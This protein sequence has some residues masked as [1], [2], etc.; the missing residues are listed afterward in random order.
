MAWPVGAFVS[1]DTQL[2]V[3]ASLAAGTYRLGVTVLNRK[4]Q[5]EEGSYLAP[6]TFD[7]RRPSTQ[8]H[9]AAD[10]HRSDVEFGRQ[11]KLAGL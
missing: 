8:F 6:S 9:C 4:T 10:A 7:D 1:G 5:A 3:P 2:N 11:I